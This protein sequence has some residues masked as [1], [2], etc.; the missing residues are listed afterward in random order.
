MRGAMSA[1][2]SVSV[3][4]SRRHV[5][6]G[7]SVC[8]RK[9]LTLGLRAGLPSSPSRSSSSSSPAACPEVG[10]TLDDRAS[11]SQGSAAAGLE[12]GPDPEP[13][14]N[15]P[16][17]SSS[18]EIV[19]CFAGALAADEP[20][21][22]S[23]S[24]N[25]PELLAG[26]EGDLDLGLDSGCPNKL[27]VSQNDPAPLFFPEAAEAGR[28]P[29][30]VGCSAPSPDLGFA[31]DGAMMEGWVG[32]AGWE[33]WAGWAGWAAAG[34]DDPPSWS[35]NAPSPHRFR[36]SSASRAFCSASCAWRS[37]I[38]KFFPPP[39]PPDMPRRSENASVPPPPLPP[40]G[41]AGDA[42]PCPGRGLAVVRSAEAE[43]P[44]AEGGMVGVPPLRPGRFA[45]EPA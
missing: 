43:G 24:Q 34:W 9:G 17:S 31:G 4:V 20:L 44:E 15:K 37:A 8:R 12:L 30:D 3:S 2:R 21:S 36:S 23:S 35:Q 39:P 19:S 26:G 45:D 27:S 41:W 16:S 38:L 42:L 25:V 13:E 1:V 5:A 7:V 32:W 33:G 22:R 28:D 6:V 18:H 40:E 11:K 10:G 14:P 29:D